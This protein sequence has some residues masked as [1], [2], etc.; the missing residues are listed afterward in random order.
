VKILL[1]FYL[2]SEHKGSTGAYPLRDFHEICRDCTSFQDALAVEIW[3]DLLKGLQSYENFKKFSKITEFE[4]QYSS[5]WAGP[6]KIPFW[7]HPRWQGLVMFFIFPHVYRIY[8]DMIALV[9]W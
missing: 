4:F 2:I 1:E 8:F 7:Y 9:R 5:P 6:P 3:M